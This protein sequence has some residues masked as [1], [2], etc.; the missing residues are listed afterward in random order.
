MKGFLAACVAFGA[1]TF[2]AL[3][4]ATAQVVIGVPGVHLR[5]G[6]QPYHYHHAYWQHRRWEERR[7]W[8]YYHGCWR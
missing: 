2:A 3:P 7:E 1:V 4:N 8:C 6:P 5:V